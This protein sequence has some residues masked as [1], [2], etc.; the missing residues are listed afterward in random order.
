MFLNYSKKKRYNKTLIPIAGIY[1]SDLFKLI[2][3]IVNNSA[4]NHKNGTSET[5]VRSETYIWE[6]IPRNYF[7]NYSLQI[8]T[9]QIKLTLLRRGH[10]IILQW[11]QILLLVQDILSRFQTNFLSLN[12]TMYVFFFKRTCSLFHDEFIDLSY[13]KNSETYW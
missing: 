2:F 4:M 9:F 8:K 3:I 5:K 12:A 13:V 6:D 1:N 11:S 7:I 10:F